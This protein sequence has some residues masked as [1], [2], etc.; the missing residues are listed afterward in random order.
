MF[1]ACLR[2]FKGSS[3]LLVPMRRNLTSNPS[4]ERKYTG[5][6]PRLP[7]RLPFSLSPS[8]KFAEL[9]RVC[10][11]VPQITFTLYHLYPMNGMP[12][13]ETVLLSVTSPVPLEKHPPPSLS[14]PPRASP[15]RGG[16]DRSRMSN[17]FRHLHR[18]PSPTALPPSSNP[19]AR[20]P[21]HPPPP[22]PPPNETT[23]RSTIPEKRNKTNSA[24]REKKKK[25]GEGRK[26]NL[27]TRY[28]H[29]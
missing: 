14:S 16:A 19:L 22:P 18:R 9:C 13:H 12:M 10:E 28:L 17:V 25:E 5:I 26:K 24:P 2:L 7:P 15:A 27:F 11:M 23:S 8:S 29:G 4:T 6:R 20:P 21:P 1:R 3:S